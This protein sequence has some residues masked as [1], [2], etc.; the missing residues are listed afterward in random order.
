MVQKDI[1]LLGGTMDMME[2]SQAKNK[3]ILEALVRMAFRNSE[4]VSSR[5]G[6]GEG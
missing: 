3:A 2:E 4:E 1:R 6:G 5:P